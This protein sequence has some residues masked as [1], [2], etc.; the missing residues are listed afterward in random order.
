VP[1]SLRHACHGNRDGHGL[2]QAAA[3]QLTRLPV[4]P[5]GR[6]LQVEGGPAFGPGGPPGSRESRPGPG[7]GLSG[8]GPRGEHPLNDSLLGQ[9]MDAE[10]LS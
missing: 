3:G 4:G 5:P 8:P 9:P 10:Q 2:S 7:A 6:E 1:V